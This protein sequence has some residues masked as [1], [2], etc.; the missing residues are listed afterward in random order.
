MSKIQIKLT[1]ILF[2]LSNG[3][4]KKISSKNY[5][6]TIGSI[7]EKYGM[8]PSQ[9]DKLFRHPEL[10][11]AKTKYVIE[12]MFEIIEEEEVLFTSDSVTEEELDSLEWIEVTSLIPVQ[13]EPSSEGL[14]QFQ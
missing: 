7:E 6:S 13:S 10:V 11:N 9:V 5:D 4:T 8:P 1:D 12:D 2:H 14:E 3:V